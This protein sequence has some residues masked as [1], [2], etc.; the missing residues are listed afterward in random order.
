MRRAS[1]CAYEDPLVMH[2]WEVRRQRSV[3]L[4]AER[5]KP[6]SGTRNLQYSYFFH[7]DDSGGPCLEAYTGNFT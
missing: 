3:Y 4:G 5:K 2:S 6:L 1:W 7:S